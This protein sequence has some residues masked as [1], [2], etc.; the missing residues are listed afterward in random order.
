M[1]GISRVCP[2]CQGGLGPATRFCPKCGRPTG[3]AAP[4]PAP[5]RPVPG[6]P[7]S[8]NPVAAPGDGPGYTVVAP[9]AAAQPSP[10][11]TVTA[12]QPAFRA[13][14]YQSPVPPTARPQALP[15]GPPQ[16]RPPPSPYPQTYQRPALEQQPRDP[17]G[18]RP[19]EPAVPPA[20]PPRQPPRR[21]DGRRSGSFPA[22]WIILLVL[23]VGGGAAGV[24]IA[25]P[26]R[27]PTPRETANAGPSPSAP[28]TGAVSPAGARSASPSAPAVTEQQA[29]ASVATMLSQSVSDRAAIGNAASDVASC[30]PNLASDPKAFDNAATS[31]KSLLASLASMTGRAA[32]PPALISDLTQAWQASVTA[33]QAYA[34]WA[35][36]EIA[37]GCVP[38][39]TND[40]GYQAANTPNRNATRYKTAF[41]AQWNP[42]AAKY[43]LSRYQQGQ[44]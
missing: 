29:A 38:D 32:L 6:D 23:L 21:H 28:G 3:F 26:F 30:G 35:S 31:R 17:Q 42:V 5:S 33:D 11:L 27:H 12:A 24:L 36:D 40:P 4:T 25:H 22:L 13:L 19:Y 15:P 41:V 34:K 20:I 44:L 2:A 8:N 9:P 14:P 1:N 16:Y 39:D 18:F 43:G 7:V 37:N 10:D